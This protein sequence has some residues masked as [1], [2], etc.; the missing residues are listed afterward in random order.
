MMCM[1]C[2]FWV[3]AEVRHAGLRGR[4]WLADVPSAILICR[5]AATSTL[6]AVQALS[7]HHVSIAVSK[8]V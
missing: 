4:W 8:S 2:Y 1:A 5:P 6:Y 3:Q 7:E